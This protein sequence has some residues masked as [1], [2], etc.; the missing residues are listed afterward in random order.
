[1]QTDYV[2]KKW[3]LAMMLKALP[4]V[5][6]WSVLLLKEQMMTSVRKTLKRLIWSALA[7]FALKITT[8]SA[9]FY[10]L[11][12][13]EVWPTN[14]REIGR[15]FREFVPKN[16]AKFDFFFQNLSEA[17]LRRQTPLHQQKGVQICPPKNDNVPQNF[18]QGDKL[19]PSDQ[20]LAQTLAITVHH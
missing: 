2:A 19:S 13:G 12:F 1:M 8:K 16:P 3:A 11:L 4:L 10:R 6:F 5:H 15:F 14:S 7:K 17:L 18:S 20:I 9:V